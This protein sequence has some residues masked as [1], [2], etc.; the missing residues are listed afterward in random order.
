MAGALRRA[1][2]AMLAMDL[3]DRFGGAVP[4]LM[5]FARSLGGLYHL[6]AAAVGDAPRVALARVY[7]D[8]LLPEAGGLLAQAQ[9]GAAGLYDLSP[10][11]LSA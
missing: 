5:G 8:R 6:R 3:N 7:I 11:D 1:T 9:Q 4:Y 2:G 10:D